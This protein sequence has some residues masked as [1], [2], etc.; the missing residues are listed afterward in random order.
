MYWPCTKNFPLSQ[1]RDKRTCQMLDCMTQ[2]RQA[3]TEK[4]LKWCL[5]MFW[6]SFTVLIPCQQIERTQNGTDADL[7]CGGWDSCAMVAVWISSF[8]DHSTWPEVFKILSKSQG[9]WQFS[10]L[11][12][13]L[14]L[15]HD[16]LLH[17]EQR[18][19]T[20]LSRTGRAIPPPTTPAVH[21]SQQEH[22]SQPAVLLL[23][24]RKT[25]RL[26]GY[27]I[28]GSAFSRSLKKNI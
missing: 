9:P 13:F 11:C 5:P 22:S 8:P 16:S 14:L 23:L 15:C 17:A 28:N 4:V 10:S 20:F 27:S 24:W 21:S 26:T 2:K 7:Q 6:T 19:C 12:T 18:R 25:K 1:M 3:G